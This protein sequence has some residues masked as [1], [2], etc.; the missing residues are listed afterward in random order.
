[1]FFRK[2]RQ[3]SRP[4]LR[5]L[6]SRSEAVKIS[7][8]D[9][10]GVLKRN[11]LRPLP[12]GRGSNLHKLGEAVKELVAELVRVQFLRRILKS[13]DFSDPKIHSLGEAVKI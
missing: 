3:A 4:P 2:K 12:D 6:H 10:E 1:M 9:R 11:D 8:R 5:K 13:H 7:S